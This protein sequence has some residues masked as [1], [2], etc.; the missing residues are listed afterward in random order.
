METRF[1]KIAKVHGELEDSHKEQQCEIER[2]LTKIA[3]L[4]DKARRNNIKFRGFSERV[5]I[6][7]LNVYLRQKNKGNFLNIH[8]YF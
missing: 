5:Q 1:L 8:D 7:Y 6:T 2:L 3:D 4:E